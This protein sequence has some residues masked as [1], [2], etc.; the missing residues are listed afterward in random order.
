MR[1]IYTILFWFLANRCNAAA[2]DTAFSWANSNMYKAASEIYDL[3]HGALVVRLKTN[4][5]SVEAYRNAGQTTLADK[6]VAERAEMNQK[7][8]AAFKYNFT[9]C[10]VYFIY[11]RS[12]EALLKHEQNIFL[13]EKLQPDTSIKLI[14]NYFLIAEYGS[15][16]SNERVDEYHYKGVYTTEPSASTASSSALFIMDTT[17]TQLQE[18]FPFAAPVYLGG[19]IKAVV[20]LDRQLDKV[21]YDKYYNNAMG[22]RD[23]FLQNFILR[24]TVNK[25]KENNSP[26]K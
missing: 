21:Y 18:P 25:M 10:K 19:F 26:K 13:N 20:Q 4:D 8:M 23:A 5:K 7:I 9:F 3:K 11:S 12:T 24:K 14:Q 1:F 6:I 16:T 22:S 2:T 15:Y 17:L